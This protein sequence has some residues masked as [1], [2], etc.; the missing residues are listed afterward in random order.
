MCMCV[1]FQ[2]VSWKKLYDCVAP[3]LEPLPEPWQER[4]TRMQKLVV[5]RCLR[6][7]KVGILKCS[8][9]YIVNLINANLLRLLSS[10]EQGCEY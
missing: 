6:P 5:L 9:L 7:D 4:L 2:L 10:K 1:Y 3:E 8:T